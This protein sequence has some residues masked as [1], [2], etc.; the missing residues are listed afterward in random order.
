[1]AKVSVS[2]LGWDL[3]RPSPQTSP[4]L[5]NIAVSCSSVI[6]GRS[7]P[8]ACHSDGARER[9]CWVWCAAAWYTMVSFG[10]LRLL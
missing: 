7:P 8:G 5:P 6:S 4:H 1:M 10:V 9:P 3:P 2:H